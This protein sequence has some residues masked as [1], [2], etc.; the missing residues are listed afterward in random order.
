MR[1]TFDHLPHPRPVVYADHDHISMRFLGFLLMVQKPAHLLMIGL[2]G[3]SLTKF[4]HHHL[5]ETRITVVDIN[6]I[7]DGSRFA[8]IDVQ[9]V[10]R[11]P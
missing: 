7:D 11:L 5:P 3:G 2:G 9:E 10:G 6:L 8:E 1:D 4:C